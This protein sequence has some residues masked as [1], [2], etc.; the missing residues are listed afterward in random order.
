[1]LSLSS[2]HHGIN[3][4][5]SNMALQSLEIFF[6]KWFR[7]HDIEPVEKDY[8]PRAQSDSAINNIAK[9]T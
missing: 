5:I 6:L 1:M 4:R 3:V 7:R 9:I 2:I 8:N